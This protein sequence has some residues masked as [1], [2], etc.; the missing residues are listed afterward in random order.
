M[1]KIPNIQKVAAGLI[2]LCAAATASAGGYKAACDSFDGASD[3][4]LSAR[5][6]Q[7]KVRAL[8]SVSFKAPPGSNYLAGDSLPVVVDDN[9]V[10]KIVLTAREG[11][12]AGGSLSFNSYA[13]QGIKAGS[14][15][16][17]A[18][19]SHWPGMRSR[20]D[21]KVGSLTCKLRPF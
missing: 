17:T 11:G 16:V 10:G 7:T 9:V 6:I 15:D 21:V 13:N 12:R 4:S 8:F 14:Y 20:P 1:R 18:F 3:V 5:Y 19:P 2:C